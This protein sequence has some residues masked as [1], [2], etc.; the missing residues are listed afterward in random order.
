[1]FFRSRAS[2]LEKK[3]DRRNLSLAGKIQAG[4]FELMKKVSAV[5]EATS[6][7]VLLYP[8]LTGKRI[9]MVQWDRARQTAYIDDV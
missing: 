6:T 3:N 8:Y 2:L 1:M 9:Y 5:F 7:F 4:Y